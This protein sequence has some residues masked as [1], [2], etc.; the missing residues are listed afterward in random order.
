MRLLA[1]FLLSICGGVAGA[2]FTILDAHTTAS[3]RGVDAVSG[4]VAWASGSGGTILLTTD[5]G[6]TWKHCAV[7]PNGEKLDFRGVQ[8]FDAKTA[9]V[10][11]SGRGS[12]SAIFK[13]T[14]G[15]A[16]WKLVFADPST[17][18][19]FDALRK[20]NSRQMYL[21][22]DQ[23]NGKFSLFYSSDQGEKW[24]AADDP[25]LEA[26]KGEGGFAASNSG[27]IAIGATLYFGTGGGPAA[28]VY[29]TYGK[30]AEGAAKG[31]SCPLMWERHEAPMASGSAGAGV[32]SL[33]GRSGAA[34]P[35]AAK[36]GL[37]A[38][39]GDYEKPDASSGT[40]ALSTDGKTW[41]AAATMPHGY[42]SAVAFDA[43]AQSWIA[44]GPNGTDV[45]R[46][47]GKNWTALKPAASDTADSDKGWNA[48]SLPFV[49]GGKGKIGR[50]EAEAVKK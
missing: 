34:T 12:Q 22:G 36:S 8:G 33:G 49:V 43:A 10:M 29:N 16:T 39:G 9:V 42:R 1:A 40:A 14:D 6:T 35:G 7:P 19:F 3:L 11:A 20:L 45:S 44:V 27:M 23:V 50:L 48:I 37:V 2:Q 26:D 28:H 24:A 41:A 25:G 15:C 32:F 46:D 13:T 17:D 30:C 4:E 47:D 21:M 18:G 31:A 38:V 5:G